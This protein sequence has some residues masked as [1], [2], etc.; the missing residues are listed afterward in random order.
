MLEKQFQGLVLDFDR[1]CDWASYLA[2]LSLNFLICEM[3]TLPIS[4][5]VMQRRLE[6]HVKTWRTA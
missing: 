3:R 4:L 1:Q 5:D 2:S 6:E